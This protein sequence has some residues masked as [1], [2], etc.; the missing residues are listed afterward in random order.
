MTSGFII[1]RDSTP[2]AAIPR[3][4]VVAMGNFDGVHLGHR[5]VIAAALQIARIQGR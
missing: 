2:P 3:G 4:A 1:I 5:A